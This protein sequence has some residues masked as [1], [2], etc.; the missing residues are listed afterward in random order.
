MKMTDVS[1]SFDDFKLCIDNLELKQGKINGLI[2]PNGCG[3]TTLMKL[4]A[5][6]IIPDEGNVDYGSL[7]QRDITMIP[8]KSY[9]LHDT[10]IKNLVYPLEL[11]KIKPDENILNNY[12]ELAG[13]SGK[14][15]KYAPGLSGGEQQK[16]AII[17]ALIFKPKLI[18]VDEAFSSLDLESTELFESLVKSEQEKE[19]STFLIV[20][21]QI[22]HI[23]RMCEYVYFMYNGKIED[24]GLTD[25][26]FNNSNNEHLKKFMSMV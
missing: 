18:F 4:F 1:K 12:L 9:F 10:V 22:A 17:R 15:N 24:E 8:R 11:R 21:H 14:D 20:S 23:H 13:L 3:K 26:L 5:G 16:L 19:Q 6:L 25:E 7:T 2:G